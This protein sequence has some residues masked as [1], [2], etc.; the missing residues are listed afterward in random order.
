MKNW[1]AVWVN[2]K[3]A[4]CEEGYGLLENAAIAVAGD[5]IAWVG[6]MQALPQLD[7]DLT[8]HDVQ[9]A[10]I[11]PG[12][13]DCHTHLVYAGSRAHEFESRL[14]GKSYTEIAEAGG[15]I[16]STVMATRAASPETL[17]QLSSQRLQALIESGVTTIEIKSGYG[18][19]WE[20]ECKLLA[21]AKQLAKYFPI[22]LQRT[23]LAA[24]TVP[25][26]FR[27][28]S[29]AY[30]NAI[31][32]TMLPQI[33]QQQL[34]ESV[35]VFCETIAFNLTQTEAIFCAAQ[36]LGL[37]IKCHAEQL[38]A[39]GAARLAAQYQAISVDHLEYLDHETIPVLAAAKTVAVLLPGAYYYLNETKLPP[40]ALLRQAKI[41]LAIASDCN[42]GTSPICSLLLIMNMAC[43][44]FKLTPAEALQGVTKHAAMALGISDRLGTLTP[45]KQADFVVW[46]VEHPRELIAN[47]GINPRCYTV[48][49]GKIMAENK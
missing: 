12:F 28:D 35:D 47:L 42:P 45:D 5:K 20:T 21:V 29:D 32:N 36:K 13:I 2:A 44:L 37:K 24:H 15:G 8:R 25:P 16:M 17:Y 9:G 30:V 38:T 33:K 48:K 39:S 7:R 6:P 23:F 40:V 46:D 27:H 19:T 22:D 14:Q 43:T 1:D 31:C 3:L 4:T 18:L 11:T 26:E 49:K 10:C 41:P 34:A